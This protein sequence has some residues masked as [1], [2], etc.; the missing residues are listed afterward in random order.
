MTG[1]DRRPSVTAI[2]V[3]W[4]AAGLIDD[5][6]G[7]LYR[8]APR[9]RAFEVV[10]VDNASSD[11]TVERI[12]ARW[13]D[14]RLIANRENVGYT[15]ANNQAIRA[16]T[17]DNLLL[18]NADAF[19]GAG[20]A[21]VLCDAL[22]AD[23]RVAIAGP[24]LVYGD[25]S[26]QRWTAGQAPSL[27]TAVNHYLFLERIDPSR[28]PGIFLGRDV[29]TPRCVDWVSSA[30]M[31][32]RRAALDRIGLMDERFFVYMD[33]VDLC[34]RARDDGWEVWYRP[35][36][37]CV[38][39]MGRSTRPE[40]GSISK[41]ALRNFNRYFAE[42]NGR[43]RTLALRAVQTAGFAARVVAYR[44]AGLA[45]GDPALHA[46]ARAH[47]AYLKLAGRTN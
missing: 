34:Q 47:W 17:S 10:V 28:F 33:D 39:L 15:R 30:C 21:D 42:R 12:R 29:R 5:C 9:G 23:P 35:D 37:E 36:A 44:A 40:A 41:D 32:V 4:N 13:P 20:C 2:V 16:S 45:R 11:G 22:D 24:R 8:H 1:A 19:V 3:S 18:V 43:A 38:H 7:A 14:V 25:G 31:V 6:L 46:K 27:R 26:W